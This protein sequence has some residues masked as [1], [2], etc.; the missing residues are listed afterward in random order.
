MASF[1]ITGQMKVKT[2]KEQFMNNFGSVLRVYYHHHFADD[3]TTLAAIRGEGAMGGEL[4]CGENDIVGDF[5][6][7]MMEL[8]G[9]EVQVA[10]PD[11]SYLVNNSLR[12]GEVKNVAKQIPEN[13]KQGK[14]KFLFNGLEYAQKGR[15]VH[16]V[17]K[18]FIE[19]NP[20]VTIE[21]L[22]KTF[23]VTTRKF[24]ATLEEAMTILD[25]NGKAGGN[26]YT[27]PEDVI[28]SKNGKVVVGNYWPMKFFTV[29]MDTVK[30]IGYSV[31]EV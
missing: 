14:S 28:S 24:V 20:D 30:K 23:N 5:E 29:F 1:K 13:G 7:F 9:I 25:S 16:A 18:R 26:Y 22:D 3:N 11:D 12:L 8:Y 21:S 4:D 15:L 17:V 2:L 31:E 19:E 10:S 27:K 6:E